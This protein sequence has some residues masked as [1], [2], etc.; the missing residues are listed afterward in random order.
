MHL[1]LQQLRLFNAVARLGSYTRAAEQMN[2]TQP[3]VSIQVKRLEEQVGLPLFEQVGKRIFLTTAGKE[4]LNASSDILGRVSEMEDTIAD[5]QGKVKGPLLLSVVSTT[6]YFLPHL[7]GEFLQQ[8]PE[9]EPRLVFTDQAAVLKRLNNNLDDFIVMGQVPE[10]RDLEA[11]PFLENILV[12][13]APPDH[14][15]ANKKN[16]SLAE[17]VKERILVREPESV[18]RKAVE[19]VL[20]NHNLLIEP[21]MEL[22][23]NEAIKQAVM[24]GLGISVISLRSLISEYH[25]K[26]LTI[27]NVD[28]FPIRRRWYAVHLKSKKLSLVSRTFLEFILANGE[29]I[30]KKTA[31][32]SSLDALLK[33]HSAKNK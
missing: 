10:N 32:F 8:Y 5:L 19:R 18:T 24:A 28:E 6:K 20:Q 1:T 2:L 26:Q 31:N 16:V 11:L 27:L 4:M 15:L 25:S 12:V 3:A 22:G 33:N 9:V 29:E 7:L 23:S 14:P 30:A 13:A 21:Y 17:F